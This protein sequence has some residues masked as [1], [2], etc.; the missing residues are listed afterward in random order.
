MSIDIDELARKSNMSAG[1]VSS[2]LLTL[3]FKN[4]ITEFPRWI[5]E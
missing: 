1:K 2:L 4:I 5:P 3:E